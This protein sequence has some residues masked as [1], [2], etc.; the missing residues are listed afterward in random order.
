MSQN[1]YGD[2]LTVLSTVV[3][4]WGVF[5]KAPS[6]VSNLFDRS[7]SYGELMKWAALVL[8]LWQG[9]GRRDIGQSLLA[10]FVLF[11]LVQLSGYVQG[12]QLFRKRKR[13]EY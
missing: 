2:L 5:P 13:Y 7:N 8:L 4:A 12:Q 6:F 3:I 11:L 9:Q 1:N 10:T